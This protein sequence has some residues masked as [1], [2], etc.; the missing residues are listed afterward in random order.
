M[1]VSGQIHSAVALTLRKSSVTHCI[2]G[3][4]GP[5]GGLEG[6]GKD[7]IPRLCRNSN[8]GPFNSYI[9]SVPATLSQVQWPTNIKNHSTKFGRLGDLAPGIFTPLLWYF[10]TARGILFTDTLD[11]LTVPVSMTCVVILRH[12][13]VFLALQPFGCIFHS[14]VAGFSLLIFEVSW[15][16]TTTR[17]SR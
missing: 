8:L 4:V 12:F 7:K 10:N 13:F 14:P 1:E 16:H 5:R 6:F 11:C 3:C 17:H 2:G 15:S 9:F